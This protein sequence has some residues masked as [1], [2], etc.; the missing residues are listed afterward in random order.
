MQKPPLI[1]E[2]KALNLNRLNK[3]SIKK[4]VR[5]KALLLSKTKKT[6]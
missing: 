1:R 6:V 3:L 2:K 4:M 5:L